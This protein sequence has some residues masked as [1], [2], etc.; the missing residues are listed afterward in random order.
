MPV[1]RLY[2]YSAEDKNHQTEV[3]DVDTGSYSVKKEKK[4]NNIKAVV[5]D[6]FNSIDN[7]ALQQKHRIPIASLDILSDRN[8]NAYNCIV[9]I[10]PIIIKKILIIN[11][12]LI[13][14]F[15]NR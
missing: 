2:D 15:K 11:K 3:E 14:F 10:I 8:R 1:I 12:Y 5:S 6:I 7:D 9:N 13:I 4:Y